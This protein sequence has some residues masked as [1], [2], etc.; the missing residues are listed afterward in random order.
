MKREQGIN[1]CIR[2]VDPRSLCL[3]PGVEPMPQLS[4]ENSTTQSPG[5]PPAP[6]S[7]PTQ[8]S[9]RFSCSWSSEF[10]VFLL[11]QAHRFYS[12]KKHRFT[13]LTFS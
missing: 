7:A 13:K 10:S 11:R 4:A 9:P 12:E 6:P 3:M 2:V 1:P 8:S 5:A